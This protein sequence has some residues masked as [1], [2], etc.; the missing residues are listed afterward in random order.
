MQ[1][2]LELLNRGGNVVRQI[3]VPEGLTSWQVV[4]MLR[5]ASP[6]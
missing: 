2:I 5:R 1:D 6:S 4:E 3:V